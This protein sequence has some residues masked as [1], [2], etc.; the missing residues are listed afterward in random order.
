MRF[1]S[2]TRAILTACALMMPLESAA[3]APHPSELVSASVRPGWVTETGTYMAALHLRLKRDWITYWRHPGESGIAP[4]LDISGSGNL[5]DVTLHWPE[6]RLY[7]KAGFASIGYVDELVL[8]IEL[9][10]KQAGRA[11]DLNAV[12]KIGVCNDICVPVDL[13][14]SFVAQDRGRHDPVIARALQRRPALATRAGL[15]AVSCSMEPAGKHMKLRATMQLPSMGAREFVLVELADK[16]VQTR[17]LP[18]RREGGTLTGKALLR[19]GQGA[20]IDR[21]KIRL[22]VFSEHGTVSHQG[23]SVAP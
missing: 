7:L 15:N 23:C 20:V 11:I 4:Q 8:P 17:V 13:Q 21:S 6:P 10:P 22:T 18:S 16:G 9:T 2:R 19:A 1:A 14:L 5:A 3:Q 12:M